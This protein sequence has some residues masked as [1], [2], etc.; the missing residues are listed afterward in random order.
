MVKVTKQ[1]TN[2]IKLTLE[3]YTRMKAIIRDFE[4]NNSD[5]HL[6]SNPVYQRF[7]KATQLVERGVELI[8]DDEVKRIIGHRYLKGQSYKLTKLFFSGMFAERTI[9]RKL[10]VGIKLITE[11][12]K[13]LGILNDLE[14][15][16]TV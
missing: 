1:E 8:T 2:L 7:V 6:L 11:S 10:E 13:M 12:A 5:T 9:D 15:S 4:K 3:Q 16:T 14:Y